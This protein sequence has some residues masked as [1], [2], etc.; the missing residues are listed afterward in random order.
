VGI[1]LE[2]LSMTKKFDPA[3]QDK[4]ADTPKQRA[5]GDKEADDDLKKGLKDSFPASDPSKIV[6]DW[7][8]MATANFGTEGK[9]RLQFGEPQLTSRINQSM[10]N[11]R[12]FT[13]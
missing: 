5:A 4:H 8:T 9:W 10:R 6:S 13:G 12:P 1:T 3:P 11:W 2:E 7:V